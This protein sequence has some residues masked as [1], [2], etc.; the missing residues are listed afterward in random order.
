M[1]MALTMPSATAGRMGA[2]AI[3]AGTVVVVTAPP[4]VPVV[5]ATTPPVPAV[6]PPPETTACRR[7]G[8]RPP[9]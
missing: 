6:A 4:T 5:P 7:L 9:R 1:K 8:P 2:M 3:I